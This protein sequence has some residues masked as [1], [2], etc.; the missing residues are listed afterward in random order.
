MA[1]DF[2]AVNTV[3][4]IR[5]KYFLFLSKPNLVEKKQLGP[6]LISYGDFTQWQFLF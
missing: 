1:G 5:K 4:E 2:Y 3:K 6:V